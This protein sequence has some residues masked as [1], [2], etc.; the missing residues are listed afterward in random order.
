MWKEL[1]S[2]LVARGLG[3]VRLVAS[4]AHPGLAGAIVAAAWQRRWRTLRGC[5]QLSVYPLDLKGSIRDD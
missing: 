2:D 1:F 3:G 4:G 5:V